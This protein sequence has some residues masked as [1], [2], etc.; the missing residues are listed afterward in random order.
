MDRLSLE[1]TTC[2]ITWRVRREVLTGPCRDH[3]VWAHLSA[4]GYG[5][6][7]PRATGPPFAEERVIYN[8]IP[9]LVGTLPCYTPLVNPELEGG[10]IWLS[11]R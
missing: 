7:V 5:I 10:D 6:D 4:R 9:W 2:H 1:R 11:S 8:D 3:G